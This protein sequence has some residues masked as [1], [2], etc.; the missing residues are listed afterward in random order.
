MAKS[1]QAV[2][3]VW[4]VFIVTTTDVVSLPPHGWDCISCKTNTMLAGNWAINSP[5]FNNSDLWWATTIVSSY[6]AVALNFNSADPSETVQQ[7]KILKSIA[8][9]MNREFKFL[10]YENSEL[11]P[12]TQE[13]TNTINA[14]PSWWVRDDNGIPLGSKQG[15]YLNHT[16]P[17]VRSFYNN[18]PLQVFGADAKD[19]LDGIFNDGMGYNP[20]RFPRTNLSRHDEWFQGKMTLADEARAI[21]G[22]LNGGEVWGNGA[23]GVTGR[24]HNYTYN[25]SLV[26]WKTALDHLDTGFLEGAGCFWYEDPN[27]GEW[28]P[29]F[30]ETFLEGVINA[31]TAGK[32]VILHFSPG[33]SN[34]PL[35]FY[36]QNA[37]PPWNKFIA[38]QWEGAVKLPPTADGVRN[39]AAEVLVQ[40]LA[41]FLIV[42]NE[43]VFLQYAWFYEMQDGNIPCPPGIECGMPSSWYPEFSKPLGPPKGPAV[44]NGPIWTREFAHASVYV[45]IRARNASKITWN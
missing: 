9:S 30:F 10:I 40:A 27:T 33:P 31:S 36:P 7:A 29:D 4:L 43:H 17:E 34:S 11:G 45:D 41:P 37:T 8:A 35:L 15:Y 19:L 24:Y 44:K 18:Y 14:N 28:I 13:A 16:L 5:Y 23:L 42:A 3:A 2:V 32:T 25:G 39:A 22:K 26:S 6:S 1:S 21:Y 38:T 20:D 12:L